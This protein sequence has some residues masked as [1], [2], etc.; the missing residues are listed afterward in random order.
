MKAQHLLEKD[1]VKSLIQMPK[2]YMNKAK[3][4]DLSFGD[5]QG[6]L[7]KK[8]NNAN[9]DATEFV[10][11]DG[12][13]EEYIIIVQVGADDDLDDFSTSLF[14]KRDKERVFICRLDY[15]AKHL[16][17]CRRD[18]FDDTHAD[19]FHFHIH[20][21]ECYEAMGEKGIWNVA[22]SIKNKEDINL[23]NFLH[24]FFNKINLKTKQ[25]FLKEQTLLEITDEISN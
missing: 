2:F 25:Y 3:P 24:F 4:R 7:N 6:M 5:I 11:H 16:R 15:H 9:Y 12:I 1:I 13:S 19:K 20:C 18:S 17:K 21:K 14:L 23:A 8:S 10:V 22:F